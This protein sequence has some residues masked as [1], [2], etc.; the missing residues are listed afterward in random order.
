MAEDIAWRRDA[1]TLHE[2]LTDGAP[3]YQP[4]HTRTAAGHTVASP[5]SVRRQPIVASGDSP[6][7]SRVEGAPLTDTYGMPDPDSLLR[8]GQPAEVVPRPP[9][10]AVTAMRAHEQVGTSRAEG[11]LDAEQGPTSFDV[12]QSGPPADDRAIRAAS[13]ETHP[14][15]TDLSAP[16]A[17]GPGQDRR[18]PAEVVGGAVRATAGVAPASP[19]HLGPSTGFSAE[20]TARERIHARY[21][22]EIRARVNRA[23]AW[24][25]ALA[26]RLEQGET[27]VA[28]GVA[29]DGRVEGPVLVTKS[30][31][32]EEFDRAAVDA[33]R[34]A[35]PFPPFPADISD[36][37]RQPLPVSLRVTFSNPVI[38]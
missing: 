29:P 18:G 1:S 26:I 28:F 32:F 19:G 24:P 10:V 4:A 11:P 14:S 5:Q 17:P 37:P 6:S 8:G 23:L 34:R 22:L 33:V 16:A 30:A 15:V 31:G 35:S 13:M 3:R 38:R 12:K 20:S 7:A 9:A 2:R 25:R 21:V 27:M 36:H